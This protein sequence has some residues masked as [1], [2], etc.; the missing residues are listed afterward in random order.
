MAAKLRVDDLIRLLR[1]ARDDALANAEVEIE[2]KDRKGWAI[3]VVGPRYTPAGLPIISLQMT[4]RLR[5]ED[6]E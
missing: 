1:K 6:D 4:T 5:G 3:R 2:D